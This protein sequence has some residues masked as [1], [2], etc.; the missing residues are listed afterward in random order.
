MYANERQE[1]TLRNTYRKGVLGAQRRGCSR[2]D[3]GTNAHSQASVAA[4]GVW[5]S[6]R[7]HMAQWWGTETAPTCYC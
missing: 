6:L 5:G 4:Q 7:P 2:A 1:G 3:H